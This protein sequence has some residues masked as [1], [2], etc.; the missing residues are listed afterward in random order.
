MAATYYTRGH[1]SQY[2]AQ[3][4]L[5]LAPNIYAAAD[6]VVNPQTGQVVCRS[7]YYNA[8][9]AFVPGGTGLSPGCK[10]I[11]F[12]GVGSVAPSAIPYTIGDSW[13]LFNRSQHV[14][15]AT[16]S[17]DLG[18]N[19]QLGAGPISV[20]TG[21]EYRKESA[22]QTTDS[23]SPTVIDAT[24]I[25][26]VP[27]A[28]VNKLGPYRFF[29]PLPFSGSY[30]VK[31][32]FAEI[33]I[34]I[35][36]NRPFARSLNADVAVRHTDYSL[37]G[38]VTTWKFGGDWQ[39][40]EDIRFRGSVSRDIRAPNLLELFN[41]ASQFTVNDLYPSSTNGVTTPSLHIS[42][43]NPNLQPEKALTQ[44][45]GLVLTPTFMQGFSLSADY[46]QIRI[47]GAIATLS[48]RNTIDNCT[49][50]LPGFCDYV[51]YA[52]GV[53][54]VLQPSLNLNV[55]ETAGVDLEA[56][57]RLD[58]FNNPLSFRVLA[59]RLIKDFSQAANG[60][61]LSDLGGDVAPLWRVSANA[62]YQV[63]DW[64]FFLQERFINAALM[65]ATQV[66]GIFTND[67]HIPAVF[68][69]DMTVSHAA[70]GGEIYLTIS[71]LFNR[72]PPV[73][74]GPPSSFSVPNAVNNYDRIGRMFNA[75][76]R[77]NL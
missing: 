45:Y 13:K 16:V 48:S 41:T 50:G 58:A 5:P 12:M 33:G 28:L 77:F 73:D 18:P 8:A 51:S 65:D 22:N 46:Y 68:Y 53:V 19:F 6:A 40:V 64:K 27:S 56:D 10:P 1:T 35:L 54:T 23:L 15:Q 71:N 76:V 34:P 63:K 72:D 26:G 39:P 32:E 69:T 25:R 47:D 49:A 9:G 59:T 36:D 75:G 57:Y 17:G 67:N 31:E 74:I 30:D 20:A 11:N 61:I 14:V 55:R 70:F 24:G 66:Q 62:T 7:Q 29:N 43:G 52:N 4:N 2:Q 44:T 21:F 60:P 42:S 3:Q 37:S 38:G